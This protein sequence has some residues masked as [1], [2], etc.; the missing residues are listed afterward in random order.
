MASDL[1]EEIRYLRAQAKQESNKEVEASEVESPPKSIALEGQPSLV[2]LATSLDK[3]G[4]SAV[5][6][7]LNMLARVKFATREQL[8]CY[9]GIP[10]RSALRYLLALQSEGL[11]ACEDDCRPAIWILKPSGAAVVATN[12]PSGGRTA[13]MSV[14]THACHRNAVE[15]LLSNKN[16]S[17]GF[18]FLDTVFLWK[19]GLNPA[20]GE[21]CGVDDNKKAYLVVL[22]DYRMKPERIAKAWERMHK[23]PRKYFSGNRCQKWRQIVHYYIVA[24]TDELRA[25]KHQIWIDRH[26]IPVSVL[27]IKP[28]WE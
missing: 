14:M 15:M 13:S 24:T 25:R 10:Y 23:P 27:T 12:A 19:K 18:R 28:L 21:H 26:D 8:A 5:D 22:D 6:V 17:P 16:D 11:V 4:G 2:P 20:F 7:L 1:A 3:S 9:S